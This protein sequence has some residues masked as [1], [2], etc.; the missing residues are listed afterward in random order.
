MKDHFESNMGCIYKKAQV[1]HH[2]QQFLQHWGANHGSML[3]PAQWRQ[4]QLLF[5]ALPSQRI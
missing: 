1:Q 5:R 2:A 3:Q 4:K